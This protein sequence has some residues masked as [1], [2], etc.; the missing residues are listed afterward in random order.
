LMGHFSTLFI[1]LAF[2]TFFELF[3]LDPV[4]KFYQLPS[5]LKYFAFYQPLHI[6]YTI[7]AGLFGQVKTY[8]WKG[9]RVK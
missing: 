3:F 9:R 8:T 6:S 5:Q 4:A 2:K 7:L 1:A